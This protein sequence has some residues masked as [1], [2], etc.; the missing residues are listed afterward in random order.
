MQLR[1]YQQAAIDEL[2]QKMAAGVKRICVIA[3]TGAGK[4]I[5]ASEIVRRANERNRR[6]VFLAHRK[7]LID[8]SVDKLLR[9]GIFSGVVMAKDS[10]EDDQFAT[11]VCSVQTLARR[12]G[13]SER[14]PHADRLPPADVVI[15]DE[16][17]HAASD[18]YRRVLS[19]WPGAI[20]VGLTATPWRSDKIGL[21]GMY[22]DT[23]VVATYTDLI[24]EGS[25]VGYD[26]FAYDA[27]DLHDMP[28]TAGDYNQKAL[29]L[30]CNTEVLIG[31]IV[32]EYLKHGNRKRAIVFAVNIDHSLNLVEQFN[33]AGVPAA[34]V[35]F[36]TPK[37]E[38]AAAIAAFERGEI[39]VLSSVSIFTEGWDCPAAEVCILARPTQSLAL[40]IQMI[41]R[42]VRPFPGK[43]RA[44]IHDHG[45]NF[46]R[47]GLLEDP[48]DYSLSVTPKRQIDL[49]TCPICCAIFGQIRDDGTCPKCGELIAPP[50]EVREA[51]ARREKELIEG[52]RLAAEEIKRRREEAA[53]GASTPRKVA[54]FLRLKEIQ[55]RK[56]Y[57][58]NWVGFR[59][60]AIFGHW[61]KFSA[62]EIAGG[63]AAKVPFSRS[64]A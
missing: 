30:A 47:H 26:P 34:H 40:F 16:C 64:V 23:V 36:N 59:F 48:R 7:E 14:T 29:S 22:D 37:R 28:V 21:R 11:Q 60:R 1:A 38:R 46:L 33:A 58:P 24:A 4:T 62:R 18:S 3:P 45:G 12:V 42:V 61:P 41:G 55:E 50:R 2:R 63:E 57:K 56:G 13:P 15:V 52:E 49:H 39:T 51:Q 53:H 17:H 5:I 19:A 6:V 31:N 54:E 43:L 25:L 44:L 8:Q 10:R 32:G 9:F 27:P 20:I 35:D